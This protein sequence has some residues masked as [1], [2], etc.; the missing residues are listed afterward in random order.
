MP[1]R[2]RPDWTADDDVAAGL[3]DA[4]PPQEPDS[5]AERSEQQP[6]IDERK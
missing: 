3:D 5:D 6:M 2:R 4:A 1:G